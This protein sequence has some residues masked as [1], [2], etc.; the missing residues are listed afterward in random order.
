M[1]VKRN[2]LLLIACLVWSAAGFNILRIGI[3]AYPGFLT[4]LNVLLSGLGPRCCWPAFY[5]V[6]T[7][8]RGSLP[9]QSINPNAINPNDKELAT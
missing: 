8:A 1:K 7:M 5:S 4:A 2:T 9:P 6:E 3:A